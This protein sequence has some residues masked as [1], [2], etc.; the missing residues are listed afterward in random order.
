MTIFFSSD[1]H[2][3]HHNI[4][5][6]C[7]RPFSDVNDMTESIVNAHNSVVGD[8][9]E[10][11]CLGDFSLSEKYVPIILPRLKGRRKYLV[12]GNHDAC[13]PCRGKKSEAARERYLQ[14]GFDAVYDL[15]KNFHGFT[16][17]H[18]P[19][20]EDERHKKRYEEYRPKDEGEWLLCGHIHQLWKVNG[21]QIN[22]G[23]D[24]NNYTPVAL[25]KLLTIAGK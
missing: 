15:V 18:M 12:A 11:W 23:V 14:Y 7:E 17:C 21:R 6:Y 3:G 9:D 10:W 13:H 24:V 4:I 22:V 5:K 8:E 19:Y 20:S 16:L 1:L 25:E 2:I